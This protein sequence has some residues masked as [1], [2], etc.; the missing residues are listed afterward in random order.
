MS[1]VVFHD[2]IESLRPELVQRVE[3]FLASYIAEGTVQLSPGAYRDAT[4]WAL[5]L[6]GDDRIIGF[7]AQRLFEQDGAAIIQIM[8]TFLAPELRGQRMAAM[9]MQG[10]LFVRAW[11]RAPHRPIFWCTRTRVPAVYRAAA[12]RNDVYPRLDAPEANRA[13]AG[14]ARRI[15][16][17]VY[18]DHTTLDPATFVLRNSYR[19]GS[20]FLPLCHHRPGPVDQAFARALNY[21]GNEAIFI[22]CRLDRL[23][24]LRYLAATMAFRATHSFGLVAHRARAWLGDGASQASW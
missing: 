18:G 1:R 12:R 5:A 7:A 21:D 6:T 16:R 8:A 20:T 17:T 22:M 11:L 3:A 2:H 15:A 24:I 23:H 4:T 9:L 13:V 14:L 19:T 10:S